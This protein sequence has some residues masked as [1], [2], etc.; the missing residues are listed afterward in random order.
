MLQA[1]SSPSVDY[2]LQKASLSRER[3]LVPQILEKAIESGAELLS[4]VR[5]AKIVGA[6]FDFKPYL[7]EVKDTGTLLELLQV[8][9]NAKLSV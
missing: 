5:A 7:L 4:V 6:N 9:D 2:V 1:K 8:I 3:D